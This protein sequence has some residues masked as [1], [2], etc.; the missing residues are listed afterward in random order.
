MIQ[1]P[2]K[3]S[4][5]GVQK[6][7]HSLKVE[8]RMSG[9]NIQESALQKVLWRFL[10]RT[11]VNPFKKK[12]SGLLFSKAYEHRIFEKSDDI[13]KNMFFRDIHI[14]SE[15]ECSLLPSLPK[16][17]TAVSILNLGESMILARS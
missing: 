6:N 16:E 2:P 15:A 11:A 8:L 12:K 17:E 7:C 13:L 5:I 10:I 9:L 14:V 1:S 4:H 3:L